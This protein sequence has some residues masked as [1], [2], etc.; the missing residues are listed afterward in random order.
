MTESQAELSDLQLWLCIRE[1]GFVSTTGEAWGLGRV[2]SCWRTF[3]P[4]A[5]PFFLLFS[6]SHPFFSSAHERNDSGNRKCLWSQLLS[7]KS[8][9]CSWIVPG[10]V[11][12]TSDECLL[13]TVR[14]EWRRTQKLQLSTNQLQL[15]LLSLSS[16]VS[17]VLQQ[18][19]WP[20][21]SRERALVSL[22]VSH[23]INVALLNSKS[24]Q[25]NKCH[26][27]KNIILKKVFLFVY[28]FK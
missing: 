12:I 21:A 25:I 28:L 11:L 15:L 1:H 6:W 4:L 24:Y 14:A 22:H 7:D 17:T 26:L 20:A 9:S 16:C 2:K 10:Q 27:L 5:F 18:S 8:R 23:E 19:H 3:C 13:V